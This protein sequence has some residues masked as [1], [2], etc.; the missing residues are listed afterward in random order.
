M[1]RRPSEPRDRFVLDVHGPNG[2]QEWA[3]FEA[4]A[5]GLFEAVPWN[6]GLERESATAQ[7]GTS[8]SVE[9]FQSACKNYPLQ[10]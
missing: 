4:K 2:P 5:E 10:F 3:P 7:A 9:R 8:S 1:P 6:R